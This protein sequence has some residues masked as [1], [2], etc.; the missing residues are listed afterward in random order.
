M[1]I[2]PHYIHYIWVDYT[3]IKIHFPIISTTS[4]SNHPLVIPP[5]F[6]FGIWQHTSIYSKPRK[7]LVEE[8]SRSRNPGK[9]VEHII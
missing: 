3:F 6:H 5:V 2:P 7:D 4:E 9:S 1:H 8:N